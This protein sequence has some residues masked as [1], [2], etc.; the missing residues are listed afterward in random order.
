MQIVALC[1]CACTNVFARAFLAAISIQLRILL[2]TRAYLHTYVHSLDVNVWV[3]WYSQRMCCPTTLLP[4]VNKVTKYSAWYLKW[5]HS[6]G[7]CVNTTEPKLLNPNWQRSGR[8]TL[9]QR[10]PWVPAGLPSLPSS[11][12]N[13]SQACA[14]L[15]RVLENVNLIYGYTVHYIWVY[16]CIECM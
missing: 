9:T 7:T 14:G 11:T 16:M 15:V 8:D 13:E 1:V 10:R 2:Y 3:C 5:E 6:H 4:S 12:Y